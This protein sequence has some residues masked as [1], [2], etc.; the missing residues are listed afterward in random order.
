[1]QKHLDLK[2]LV[3]VRAGDFDTKPADQKASVQ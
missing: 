2:K 1:L 3:I